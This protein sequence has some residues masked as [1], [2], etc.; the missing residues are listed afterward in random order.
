MKDNIQIARTKNE[1]MR[2]VWTKKELEWIR[3]NKEKCSSRQ[4][5]VDR[6]NRDG[7]KRIF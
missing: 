7:N 4:E 5:V 3:N 1:A 2:K 6:F